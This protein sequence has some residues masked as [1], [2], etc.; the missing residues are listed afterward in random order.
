MTR[1]FLLALS[2]LTGST[3]AAQVTAVLPVTCN[4]A[5]TICT[6]ATPV[7]NPDGSLIGAAGGSGNAVTRGA[8]TDGSG[9]VATG[10]TSQQ[11]FTANAGR[12]YLMC[13]N[14]ITA[15]ETLFVSLDTSASTVSGSIELAP[16]TSASFQQQF[17]PNGTVNIT[18]ATAGHRYTCKQG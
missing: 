6:Q 3:A 13:Q 4:A 16:G 15:T 17:I 18:A 11:V 12:S 2:M 14:P 8:V 5:R 9:T 10:G 7:T 1:Y